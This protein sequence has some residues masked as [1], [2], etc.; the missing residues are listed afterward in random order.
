MIDQ[1]KEDTGCMEDRLL[2]V[3]VYGTDWFIPEC[4]IARTLRGVGIPVTALDTWVRALQNPEV[5]TLR[6]QIPQGVG[7]TRWDCLMCAKFAA[8][9]TFFVLT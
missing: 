4:M 9:G 7:F 6:V 3:T 5:H 8:V 1:R 2:A